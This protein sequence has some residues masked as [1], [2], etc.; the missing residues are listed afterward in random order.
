MYAPYEKQSC[1]FVYAELQ[2]CDNENLP[3]TENNV[4]I[5]AITFWNGF[6]LLG[7]CGTKFRIHSRNG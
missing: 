6:T 1:N 5:P 2:T 7:F 3:E 4:Q